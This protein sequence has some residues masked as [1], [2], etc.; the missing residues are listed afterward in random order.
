MVNGC[1][2]VNN[3]AINFVIIAMVF[4]LHET[5]IFLSFFRLL[6]QRDLVNPSFDNPTSSLSDQILQKQISS[7]VLYP[8]YKKPSQSD[9]HTEIAKANLLV[10]FVLPSCPTQ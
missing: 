7:L 3:T 4:V 8:V 6:I 1:F 2:L 5:I 10:Y 9:S